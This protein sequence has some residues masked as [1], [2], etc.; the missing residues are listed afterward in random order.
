M[1]NTRVACVGE[2]MVELSERADGILTRSF[3]G[4]TLNT[5]I[6][7]ARLGVPTEYVTVLGDDVFSDEMLAAWTQEGIGTTLIPRLPERLPGMYLIRTDTDGERRFYYWR[8]SAPVRQLF[9]LQGTAAIEEALCQ[10]GMIYLSGITLSL[11]DESS[12]DRLF[13]VLARA[14][15]YGARVAFDTNFRSRGWPDVAVA[16]RVYERAFRSSDLVFVSVEDH[17]LLHGSADPN[18]VVDRLRGASVAEMV[19]KFATPACRVIADGVDEDGV[20]EVVQATPVS[21]VID[22]T[23]AGDS[24]AAAYIAA[25]RAGHDPAAAAQ[26]GHTL[27]GT[28]VQHRGAI[29]PR[30]V[31]PAILPC[32]EES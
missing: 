23:A 15:T 18:A 21:G 14:R 11:F 29:I 12:R 8:D 24:F 22:T 19:V 3:G 26:A 32:C 10:A 7:L 27:A 2:C 1:S 30:A 13:Q 31:M 20:D 17:T 9:Q 4:D 28:V 6:Y 25:R 16:R 5:A